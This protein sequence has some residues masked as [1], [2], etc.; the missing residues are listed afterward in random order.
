MEPDIEA[1]LYTELEHEKSKIRLHD[2]VNGKIFLL[3]LRTNNNGW[4]FKYA[5][6]V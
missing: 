4:T 6:G 3:L 2:M 5:R 1:A